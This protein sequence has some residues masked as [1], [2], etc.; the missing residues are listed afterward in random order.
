MLQEI[1]RAPSLAA[2]AKT[3][4]M[5]AILS[6]EISPGAHLIET[7]LA[8]EF[9]ISRGPIRE[10]LNALAA[11]GL[12]EMHPGRGAF[13]ADPS[14]DEM[15]DMIV[16]RAMLN[17]MAAR[18]AAANTDPKFFAALEDALVRM[19]AAEAAGDEAAF[20]DGHWLFY[21]ALFSANATLHRAWSTLHG[22]IDIYV[23]RMGRPFLPLA[24][25]RTNYERFVALFRAGDVS[26]AEAVVRSQSL[27]VGFTVLER[28]LPPE[29]AG[30]AT[31]TI[32]DDGD[33]QPY[34]AS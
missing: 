8:G 9:Q 24:T 19:R 10:A 28:T 6:G 16:L 4:I 5:N 21:E 32:D 7:R 13:V 15:Q 34:V 20:F 22:L 31:Y 1:N 3:L 11:D 2:R 12:V 17:G 14:P 26:L 18:Y 30:Y 27:I 25:I 29:L 33:I 23:R